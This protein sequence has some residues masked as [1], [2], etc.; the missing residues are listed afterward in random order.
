M[1]IF[2][3]DLNPCEAAKSLCDKHVPKMIVESAQ[4]MASALLANGAPP[5]TMPLTKKGTHYKGGYHRHPCTLWTGETLS[6]FHW[7]ADHAWALCTEYRFRYGKD[8]ACEEPILDMLSMCSYWIP[9]GDR[10][11][12]AQAMPDEYRDRLVVVAYR[13]YYQAEKSGF[14]KW[15][16][17]RS[18]PIWWSA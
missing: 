15:E 9:E 14:A 4:M 7:L 5:E 11:P 13:R 17:G 18:P 1:N 2:V 10:T 3:V 16:R 8:H 12:F 6:N